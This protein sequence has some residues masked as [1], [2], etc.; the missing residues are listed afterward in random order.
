MSVTF[1]L[2]LSKTGEIRF[3]AAKIGQDKNI[4]TEKIVCNSEFLTLVQH[5]QNC[6]N[7]GYGHQK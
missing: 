7:D 2:C 4:K 1:C 5:S 3:K 6:K